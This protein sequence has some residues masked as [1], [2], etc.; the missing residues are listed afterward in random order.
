MSNIIRKSG[1]VAL[2]VLI[3]AGLIG[4]LI[5]LSLFAQTVPPRGPS[6]TAG[7]PRATDNP[8]GPQPTFLIGPIEG[9]T[10]A[11]HAAPP[12]TSIPLGTI[13]QLFQPA[14]LDAT[15]IWTGAD[16][17][18]RD[19]GGSTAV[20]PLLEP[21]AQVVHVQ[22]VAETG[23]VIFGQTIFNVVDIPVDEITAS[24]TEVWVDPVEI[25]ESLPQDELNQL[26]YQYFVGP[27][28]AGLRDLGLGQ[29]RTSVLRFVHMSVDVDPPR[30]RTT[31]HR[32]A[33]PQQEAPKETNQTKRLT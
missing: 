29:Y 20:C 6:V 2:P 22:V 9:L 25:D 28:I 27:S 11:W 1:K 10:T 23:E 17:V 26:T 13:P 30:G 15:V 12:V 4:T 21:G 19:A 8:T 16:E 32:L 31:T 3:M 18:A 14:P 24:L 5:G 33:A 7:F